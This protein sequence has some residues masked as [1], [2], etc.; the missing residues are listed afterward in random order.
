VLGDHG[1]LVAV[2]GHRS[3]MN[4]LLG[5]PELPVEVRHP[6]LE[7]AAEEARYQRSSDA[8]SLGSIFQAE[9]E[10]QLGLVLKELCG[11]GVPPEVV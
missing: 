11:E 2:Q 7:Y 9:G 3:S 4:T 6:A 1:G 8:I 5:V 10:G